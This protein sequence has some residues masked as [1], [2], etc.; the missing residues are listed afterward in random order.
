MAEQ[1]ITAVPE[2]VST[3]PGPPAR[4]RR[5][6]TVDA[7]PATVGRTHASAR[8]R[9]ADAAQFYIEENHRRSLSAVKQKVFGFKQ[10]GEKFK[11]GKR[12]VIEAVRIL[13]S[14]G[15][16][17]ELRGDVATPAAAPEAE[18]EAMSPA[19][20]KSSA[21]KYA[22]L[23]YDTGRDEGVTLRAAK[24]ATQLEFGVSPCI[25][26]IANCDAPGASPVKPGKPPPMGQ[27]A[28]EY[29]AS[30]VRACAARKLPIFK[31]GIILC[32][33]AI[34]QKHPHMK[35]YTTIRM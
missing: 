27:M 15:T 34:V 31:D 13:E 5:T 30:I 10:A 19:T 6:A 24:L 17:A 11:C 35:Q 14:L 16:A 32:A 2:V 7:S 25:T 1:L 3:T 8:G 9:A 23:L 4:R 22:T 29:L 28:E 18:A 21:H 20:L 26:T 33:A 12:Q